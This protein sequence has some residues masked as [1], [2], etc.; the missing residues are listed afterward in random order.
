MK[1]VYFP[2]SGVL[3]FAWTSKSL[4]TYKY[5]RL[6]SGL[7]NTSLLCSVSKRT[8]IYKDICIRVWVCIIQLFYECK[9]VLSEHVCM[10]MYSLL[11][12][13]FTCSNN[14]HIRKIVVLHTHTHTHEYITN[15]IRTFCNLVLF[16]LSLFST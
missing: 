14:T 13:R 12:Q 5:P 1:L 8:Y 9:C 11:R 2:H 3:N 15:N 6:A 16:F 7:T 4:H 10:Y